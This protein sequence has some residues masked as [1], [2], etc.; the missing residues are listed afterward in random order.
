MSLPELLAPAGS[1]GALRAAV[2]AGAD[3]V[4]L[5]GKRFGARRYADNFSEPELREAVE[6]AHNRGVRVY[7]TANTLIRDDEL[8]EVA[9]YLL[10][11]YEIGA[12]AVLVQD[13]GVAALA[14]AVV[15]DLDLHASTQM[16]IHNLE[17]A[18]WAARK[19]FKRA[20]LARELSLEEVE[21]IARGLPGIGLEVFVHGAL[22]YCYSGQ[23]LLSSLLGGRSGNRGMC[24]QPCRKRYALLK[25]DKDEYGRPILLEA[26]HLKE[27][28]LLSTCD[29][30]VYQHLDR[31]VKAPIV[32][33]K[34]EGRMKSPEYV[35]VVIQI[36]RRA[37]D[38]LARGSWS[39]SEED[40]RDLALAFNRDFTCG[41]LLGS[42]DV[43]GREMSEKRGI[44]LGTVISYN[45]ASREASISLKGPAPDQGDG[46]VFLSPGQEVGMVVHGRASVS[47]GLL[48]LRTP[49]RVRPGSKVYLTGS[50][51]LSRRAERIMTGSPEPIPIDLGVSWEEGIPVIEARLEAPSGPLKVSVRGSP[52]DDAV[53]RPLTSEQIEA[54]LRRTGGTPFLI[55]K[56]EM[57]YPGGLFAPLGVLNQLRRDLLAVAEA[58]LLDAQRPD[59]RRTREAKERLDRMDLEVRGSA[60]LRIP[61]LAAYAD[62]LDTVRGAAEGGCRRIYFEPRKLAGKK[63]LLLQLSEARSLAGDAELVWK[64]PR[65]TREKHISFVRP[66]LDKVDADGI[67]VESVGAAEAASGAAPKIPLFGSSGL[68]VWN[69]MAVQSLSPPFHRL[70]L[71]PE[72]SGE[73]LA[74]LV[75]RAPRP[76]ALE[77]IVQGSQEVMVAEDRLPAMAGK[78]EFWGLQDFRRV[79]PV[80]LDG[81]SRTVILNSVETCL[82]DHMPRL[83]EIGLDGIAI[84]A[85]SRTG[86]YAREISEIYLEAM[87]LTKAGGSDLEADLGALKEEVKH[88]S[89]G[90]I[91]TGH[92]LRGLRDE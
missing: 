30:C 69:H 27:R 20:V 24:A 46:L 2:A 73:Q 59:A 71:S 58:A 8:P 34:V 49:E 6:F 19:G 70:T 91:T 92:F 78:A 36:Y 81:E 33:L 45:A 23:C 3:A 5:G 39:P 43:M 26:V 31:V 41:H 88:R 82:I 74:R 12:D 4:Y 1:P 17:G 13:L 80:L 89:L 42:M 60:V 57:R 44:L 62:G 29:L 66:L 28:F 35:A 37:L 67:M 86:R 63:E 87:R 40:L 22:C 72:L 54:Q 83:F 21:E 55:R 65:I 85:R 16:T 11:L 61:S 38:A 25:G 75:A 77:I 32:S 64:W 52:M 9:R 53:K 56:L 48:R 68:N 50:A 15:P 47:S 7:V 76:P 18:A 10:W 51:G 90:G 14:R 79:F 84:D